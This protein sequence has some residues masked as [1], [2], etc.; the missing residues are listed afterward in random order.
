MD[1]IAQAIIDKF[2]ALNVVCEVLYYGNS[3]DH[4]FHNTHKVLANVPMEGHK[5]FDYVEGFKYPFSSTDGKYTIRQV[6][7]QLVADER[8]QTGGVFR[9][10]FSVEG[11]CQ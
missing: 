1:E 10:L 5:A 3:R 8:D 11:D 4:S 9:F 2:A 7:S 6:E